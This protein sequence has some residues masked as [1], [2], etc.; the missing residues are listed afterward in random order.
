MTVIGYYPAKGDYA[1]LAIEN[2]LGDFLHELTQV[3]WEWLLA[4]LILIA[5]IFKSR[6]ESRSHKLEIEDDLSFAVKDVTGNTEPVTS[7]PKHATRYLKPGAWFRTL[8]L[9]P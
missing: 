5:S 1:M 8:N 6:L 3:H 4:T 2:S 7:N 9:E